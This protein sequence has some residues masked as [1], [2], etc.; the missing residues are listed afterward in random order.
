MDEK[1]ADNRLNHHYSILESFFKGVRRYPKTG[2]KKDGIKVNV[3]IHAKEGT[4]SYE[5]F[6]SDAT[7]DSFRFQPPNLGSSDLVAMDRAY[8]DYA[9]LQELHR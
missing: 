7:N 9:K 2:T 1:A 6:I 5:R 8:H 3:V 4:P